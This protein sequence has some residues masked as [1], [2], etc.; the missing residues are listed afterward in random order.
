MLTSSGHHLVSNIRK[1]ELIA[2][3]QSCKRFNFALFAKSKWK[4]NIIKAVKRS[5]LPKPKEETFN[6]SKTS[7]IPSKYQINT[8]INNRF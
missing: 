3:Y 5:L 8:H 6:G 4:W 7:S 2:Y 1:Y